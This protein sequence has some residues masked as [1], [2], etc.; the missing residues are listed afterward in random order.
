MPATMPH[1]WQHHGVSM[2]A[3][4]AIASG[5]LVQCWSPHSIVLRG[6]NRTGRLNTAN[7][8]CLLSETMP[9]RPVAAAQPHRSRPRCP[10]HPSPVQFLESSAVLDSLQRRLGSPCPFNH[11]FFVVQHPVMCIWKDGVRVALHEV[12]GVVESLSSGSKC[13]IP[14]FSVIR[15]ERSDGCPPGMSLRIP[16]GTLVYRGYPARWYRPRWT[17]PNVY[18]MVQR[19]R[20]PVIRPSAARSRIRDLTTHLRQLIRT[21]L[22]L[23]GPPLWS[24]CFSK[25]PK[26]WHSN[27]RSRCV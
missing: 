19:R 8:F 13:R 15:R 25:S 18:C 20:T 27:M 10:Q 4:L 5:G 1:D 22:L 7:L 26:G 2:S 3:A 17:M 6:H 11:A 12:I 16:N 24:W 14:T 9:E 23:S 21:P